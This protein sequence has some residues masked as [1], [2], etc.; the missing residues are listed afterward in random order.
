MDGRSLVRIPP[1]TNSGKTLRLKEKGVPSREWRKRRPVCGDS[2]GRAPPTDERVRNL[3]KELESVSP[4]DHGRI[5][6]RRLESERADGLRRPSLQRNGN[7]SASEK[8]G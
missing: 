8:T 1:G 3:M 5:C 7:G 4:G 2:S 6:S